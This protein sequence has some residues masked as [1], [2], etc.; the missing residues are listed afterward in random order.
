MYK[1][2]QFD[3]RYLL[4]VIIVAIALL[5]VLFSLALKKEKSL[6][7]VE[8]VVK[9]AGGTVIRIV[10][11]PFNFVKNEIKTSKE[12]NDIY[13]KY[14]KLKNNNDNLESLIA[15]NENLE[16]EVE[17]LKESLKLNTLLSDKVLTNA[18]I[19][20]RNIG[21]FYD[22]ITIDK[23]KKDGVEK[24][25]A[26]VTPKG[27]IGKTS[28]ISNHTSTVK[29]LS[30]D[31]MDNKIS[32]KV[33]TNDDYAYGLITKYNSKTN[34]YTVEGISQSTQIPNGADVVTTGMGSNFPSGLLVGKVIGMDTDNFDLSKVLKVK[35]S[36]SFDDLDY[37]TIVKREG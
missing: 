26:V 30:N 37:V 34:T 6:N 22:E 32:V 27:L 23:G 21:Y 12:K 31:K 17:K 15:S 35:A 20:H 1:K 19:I 7:P 25:M 11:Y 24:N 29:L 33:K 4:I 9:D 5:L 10:S 36:V 16:S 3:K 18:S 28:K 14:K 13:K 2:N 8:K